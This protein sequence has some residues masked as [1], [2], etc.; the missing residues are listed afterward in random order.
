VF[1]LP[2]SGRHKVLK[3]G[4]DQFSPISFNRLSTKPVACLKGKPNSTLIL[5]Q[6]YMAASLYT[7]WWLRL[8]EGAALQSIAASNQIESD[9]RYFKARS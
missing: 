1:R 3:S 8:P 2:D 9:P 7:C 4:T 5:K 6:A